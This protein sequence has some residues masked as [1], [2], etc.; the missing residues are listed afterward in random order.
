MYSQ[1]LR[2]HWLCH[3]KLIEMTVPQV[4]WDAACTQL[5]PIRRPELSHVTLRHHCK[6]QW[7]TMEQICQF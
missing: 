2:R 6:Q 3:G 5:Q 4:P 7:W 1:S